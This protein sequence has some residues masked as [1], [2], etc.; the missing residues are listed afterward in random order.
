MSQQSRKD[1][2]DAYW[3]MLMGQ[4][5]VSLAGASNA[6]LKVQVFDVLDE[7]FMGSNCWQEAVTFT[8]IPNTLDYPVNVTTG[9]ISKLY[10]VIDQN[11]VPQPAFMPTVGIIHVPFAYTT[12][13]P[14]TAVL[15]K[16]VTDPL[17]CFP[18]HIPDWTLP[19]Y[20]LGL[21][22]GVLG[23]MMQQPGM[24]WSNPQLALFHLQKFRD[25]ISH[26]RVAMTTQNAVGA[27]NWKFPQQFRVTGQKGGV[28]TFNVTPAARQT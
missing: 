3:M 16:T 1:E 6:E 5:Q 18:P 27:Q 21:Q 25:E 4:V 24:S 23:N 19:R 15:T 28:S 17:R 12:V 2:H 10:A 9:R 7:F 14:M 8:V 13:Q 20:R 26:A 22:H 11:N